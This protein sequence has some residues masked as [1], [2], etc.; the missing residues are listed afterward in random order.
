MTKSW[1][2]RF[3]IKYPEWGKYKRRLGGTKKET[4][5]QEQDHG[6]NAV[7]VL[8]NELVLLKLCS[9]SKLRE[10]NICYIN[11]SQM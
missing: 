5:T 9:I 4:N 7:K 1:V 10:N 6:K 2:G 8:R 11:S 3:Q